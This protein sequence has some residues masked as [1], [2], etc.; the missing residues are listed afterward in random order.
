MKRSM[1]V[2]LLA[3]MTTILLVLIVIP[4]KLSSTVL[5]T[6]VEKIIMGIPSCDCVTG[7][8]QCGCLTKDIPID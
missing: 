8:S 4:T 5:N 6:G 2:L 7:G 1:K 3:L